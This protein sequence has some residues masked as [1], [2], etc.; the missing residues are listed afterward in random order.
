[1]GYDIS[2]LP[3]LVNVGRVGEMN[4]CC[5]QMLAF[6]YAWRTTT[7]V[8]LALDLAKPIPLA[9]CLHNNTQ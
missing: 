4:N 2:F 8:I 1:M 9:L 7:I 5:R 6:L 3:S